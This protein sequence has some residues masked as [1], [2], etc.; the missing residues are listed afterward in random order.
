MKK[1]SAERVENVALLG[2]GTRIAQTVL[3][4]F[5]LDSIKSEHNSIENFMLM[6][7]PVIPPE[8]IEY[9][10]SGTSIESRSIRTKYEM[11]QN[12]SLQYK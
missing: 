5:I 11:K 10:S 6:L 7:F 8:K 1:E 2:T 12:V 4:R 9:L 3:I